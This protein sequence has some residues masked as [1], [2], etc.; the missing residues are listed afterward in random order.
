MNINRQLFFEAQTVYRD[1]IVR[2]IR[3]SFLKQLP[4]TWYDALRQTCGPQDWD[5]A[6]RSAYTVRDSGKIRDQL[7]DDFEL[8]DVTFFHNIF[9]KYWKELFPG[10][11]SKAKSTIIFWTNE[12]SSFRH[13]TTGHPTAH[14]SNIYDT[15]RYLDSAMRVLSHIDVPASNQIK[16]L[17]D[18]LG[19]ESASDEHV[20]TDQRTIDCPTLP[21]REFIAPR[22]VG[23]QPELDELNVWMNDPDSDIWLLAGAGGKGKTAIA[24]Q[25]ATTLRHHPPPHLENLIWLSA[26][27]RRFESG[28]PI[29]IDSPD[30][31]D[32]DSALDW[33]LEA[34]GADYEGLD[35]RQKQD[36]CLE[37]LTVFPTLIVFDDVD[38]LDDRNDA[39]SFFMRNIR[40]TSSRILLTSRRVPA[41]FGPAVTYVQ[42]LSEK[43]GLKFIDSRI[44]MYGLQA[45]PITNKIRHRILKVCDGSPLFIQDLMRLCKLG[46]RPS[47]AIDLWKGK[48]GQAAREYTLLRELEMLGHV[49]EQTLLAC[50]LYGGY[51]SLDEI[52]MITDLSDDDCHEAIAALQ[53]QF[54]VP[55]PRLFEGVSRFR[56]N[57]NTSRLV[58]EAR[59]TSDDTAK[60][61]RIIRSLRGGTSATKEFGELILRYRRRADSHVGRRE[62]EQ[63]EKLL[64]NALK[65][66]PESAELYGKLGWVYKSWQPHQRYTDARNAFTRASEFKSSN[67]DMYWQWWFMEQRR[68]EW[69]AASEAAERGLAIIPRSV[70]L[71]FAAGLARSQRARE[72]LLVNTESAGSEAR[73]AELLLTKARIQAVEMDPKTIRVR[74][75]FGR[76][77]RA[78]LLN[79][80][81]L[82][83]VSRSLGD[84]RSVEHYL[85]QGA[86]VIGYWTEQ[87]PNEP[88]LAKERESALRRYPALVGVRK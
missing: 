47:R 72:L 83:D 11:S 74:L 45:T 16:R 70:S 88:L 39:M 49:A 12:V 6:K 63:A 52:K 23:R 81:R 41:F 56:L 3:N 60:Y 50:A 42:G 37:Y 17:L 87:E 44:E 38:T 80:L 36:K 73:R 43:D 51:I 33:I 25:F 68:G 66:Y 10:V 26:K 13:P 1:A 46:E 5:K 32:L 35:I 79:H 34:S 82:A 8:I 57:E 59:S 28:Q 77:Y 18:R 21:T 64:L 29:P 31:H 20:L 78:M 9:Q 19:T 22:F 27:G 84:Q 7:T 65:R 71:L 85:R 61:R 76:L 75:F 14:D 54:L 40:S 2:H 53:G 62:Y 69:T 4:D 48:K 15:R 24:Y 55:E 58:C 86:E 30:F 67:E